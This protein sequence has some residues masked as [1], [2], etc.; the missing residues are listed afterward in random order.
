MKPEEVVS[1]VFGVDESIIT[2]GTSNSTLAQWDS[3]GHMLLVLEL[4]STYGLQ[5][6]P[7]TAL[8]LTS[9]GSI[10]QHLNECGVDW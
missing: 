6:S 5:L 3:M 8:N 9:V 7:E 10:K 2:D 1:R 4:E